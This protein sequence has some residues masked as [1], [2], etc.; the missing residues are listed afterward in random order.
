VLTALLPPLFAPCRQV[1]FEAGQQGPVRVD[2]GQQ[3]GDLPFQGSLPLLPRLPGIPALL[4]RIQDDVQIDG[5]NLF[6][7]EGF[8]VLERGG[9]CLVGLLRK[10]GAFPGEPLIF[11][12]GGLPPMA[13]IL[14]GLPGCFQG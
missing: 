9:A 14:E 8:D 11:Q 7:A 6:Y 1:L 3:F 4:Q 13:A 5:L 10:G 12:S 2:P